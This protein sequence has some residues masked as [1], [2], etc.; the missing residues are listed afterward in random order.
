[1]SAGFAIREFV[2]PSVV[3]VHLNGRLVVHL[4]VLGCH[5]H[6]TV[7]GAHTVEGC[8]GVL[9]HTHLLDVVHVEVVELSLI[10]HYTVYD[11][12][13][14]AHVAYLQRCARSRASVCLTAVYSGNLSH[15]GS[16]GGGCQST[17]YVLVAY[18]RDGSRE[19]L[20]LLCETEA[21]HHNLAQSLEV[22]LKGDVYV[23]AVVHSHGLCG[24]TH[25]R[26][27]EDRSRRLHIDGV[28]AVHIGYSTV[29]R[30]FLGNGDAYERLTVAVGDTTFYLFLLLRRL[31]DRIFQAAC[32]S[33]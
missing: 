23:G 27:F 21:L 32:K 30:A 11:V 7:G 3:A 28:V 29:L 4:A 2:L 16:R 14:S 9:Q 31:H 5:D 6:H 12:E 1:M 20:F 15:K 13:R 33:I 22:F 24:V 17:R 26:H 19:R 25:I 8:G 10:F 18:A